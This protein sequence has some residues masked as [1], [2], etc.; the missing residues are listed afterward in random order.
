MATPI[1][2]PDGAPGDGARR[3]AAPAFLGLRPGPRTCVREERARL[4]ALS[5]ERIRVHPLAPTIGAEIA[6]V[7]L[8]N[9]DDATFDEVRR[10]WLAFKVVFFR[11]QQIDARQQMAFGRRFG[12][13]EHHPFLAANAAH[14]EIVRFEKDEQTVGYENLWH[15]DVS[16]REKPALASVLRAIEVPP[17]GGDTLFADMVTAYEGLDAALKQRIEGL[18]AVHDFTH[19]FGR[20][21]S[22]EDL[23]AKQ[24]QFP[25]VSHP[26][27]RTHPETGR[28]I[29]YVNSIFTRQIEG[30]DPDEGTALLDLLCRQAT[31]PEYQC[32]FRWEKGSVAF[33]DNRAVQHYAASDYWPEQRVMERIAIVGERPR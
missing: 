24:K 26:V 3:I 14:D 5:F 17:L 7:D 11:D 29:L 20:G 2:Q 4:A 23:A 27:V 21:L 13:L 18:T 32:R 12:E 30:L 33:W 6:G 19:S 25:A 1:Q 10:A 15:S 28:R 9:L 16:W 8:G 22:A 31:V